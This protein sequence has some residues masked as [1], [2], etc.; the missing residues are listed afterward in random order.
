MPAEYPFKPPAFVMLTPSGRFETG[1]KICLSI[2]SFHPESWQP[3]WSVRSAL[4]ALIAF[5]QTPG[6]GAVGSIET[7]PDVR[8]QMAMEARNTP[9][10]HANSDIQELINTQHQR[11]LDLEEESRNLFSR[12]GSPKAAEAT[13]SSGGIDQPEDAGA[14]AGEEV[15]SPSPREETP[16]E[17]EASK[18]MF[19]PSQLESTPPATPA[20]PS[21][22]AATT[23]TMTPLFQPDGEAAAATPSQLTTPSSAAPHFSPLPTVNV[24]T[25]P[26]P[27]ASSSIAYLN[28]SNWEDKGLSFIAVLLG[29]MVV[30]ILL[31]RMVLAFA[32]ATGSGSS[33]DPLLF[34]VNPSA[35]FDIEL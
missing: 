10:K 1:T 33:S 7:A 22:A 34:S 12:G 11:M 9:P 4:I 28:N 8:K 24:A 35:D 21:L 13:N 29:A 31:R 27:H 6:N 32:P 15:L 3:S 25:P 14:A 26:A 2:S 18:L 5:M 20:S 17:E 19:Q 23:P 30:A 16:S